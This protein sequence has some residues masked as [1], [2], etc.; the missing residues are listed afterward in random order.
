VQE[1]VIP[2]ESRAILSDDFRAT[3]LTLS[4]SVLDLKNIHAFDVES[5]RLHVCSN[6]LDTER[7][8]QE[9][10]ELSFTV[11]I[12]LGTRAR[13]ITKRP[14]AF[15]T[16]TRLKSSSFSVATVQRV[17]PVPV[18]ERTKEQSDQASRRASSRNRRTCEPKS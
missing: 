10:N 3:T 14:Q 2:G 11:L 16:T 1:T 9:L 17:R 4:H 8:C 13:T 5:L 12:D 15:G 6:W 18:Y 7:M